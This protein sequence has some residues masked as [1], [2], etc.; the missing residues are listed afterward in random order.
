MI[1]LLCPTCRQY[2][3]LAEAVVAAHPVVRCASCQGLIEVAENL[4]SEVPVAQARPPKRKRKRSA[5]R[6][7]PLLPVF[8]TLGI[9]LLVGLSVGVFFLF[10]GSPSLSS[11]A[12]MKE[13]DLETMDVDKLSDRTTYLIE[14]ALSTMESIR[15]VNDVEPAKAKLHEISQ[16][17]QRVQQALILKTV[18]LSSEEHRLHAQK[19]MMLMVQRLRNMDQRLV[20]MRTRFQADAALS[21]KLRD[22]GLDP[23][24][25]LK[26][27]K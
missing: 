5:Q 24:D 8:I 25:I 22:A 2:V 9:L 11:L 27:V 26:Q 10:S 12:K 6:Q 13:E 7:S 1:R 21:A 16:E 18:H 15:G 17:M 20:A 4:V 14:A 3:K 19:N 23:D